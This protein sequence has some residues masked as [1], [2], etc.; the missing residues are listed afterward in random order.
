[1]LRIYKKKIATLSLH[2]TD[3]CF[4]HQVEELRDI[5]E[6]KEVLPAS[7]FSMEEGTT[8]QPMLIMSINPSS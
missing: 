5:M 8:N 6:T 2:W 3:D 4:C 1:M 7:M